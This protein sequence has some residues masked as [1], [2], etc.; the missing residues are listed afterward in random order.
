MV[1]D[2]SQSVHLPKEASKM[3]V[4]NNGSFAGV[5]LFPDMPEVNCKDDLVFLKPRHSN[6]LIITF[7]CQQIDP[8]R[9]LYNNKMLGIEMGANIFNLS[10]SINI[11]FS[12]VNKVKRS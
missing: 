12:D 7:Y 4:E 9:S 3:A 5:L 10:E 1:M 6:L 11:I 2:F 8:N